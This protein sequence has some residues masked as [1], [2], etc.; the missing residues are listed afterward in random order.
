MWEGM[1]NRLPSPQSQ[2]RHQCHGGVRHSTNDVRFLMALSKQ[3]AQKSY[4]HLAVVRQARSRST[5]HWQVCL[6]FSDTRE[7]FW[8]S[9]QKS[10]TSKGSSTAGNTQRTADPAREP[11]WDSPISATARVEPSYSPLPFARE[12]VF[13]VW[14]IPFHFNHNQ[15]SIQR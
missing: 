1:G 6:E 9:E 2:S 10:W 12:S 8:A 13:L 15:P 4:H 11:Q 3:A 14:K 7:S 5:Q